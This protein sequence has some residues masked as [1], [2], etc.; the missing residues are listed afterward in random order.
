MKHFCLNK[1]E[2]VLPPKLSEMTEKGVNDLLTLL[3]NKALLHDCI[4]D[5]RSI[6][7]A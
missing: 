4:I 1:L 5:L 7:F 6:P 3:K 2:F